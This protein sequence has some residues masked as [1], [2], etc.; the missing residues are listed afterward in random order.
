MGTSGRRRANRVY[1]NLEKTRCQGTAARRRSVKEGSRSSPR[2]PQSYQLALACGGS[3]QKSPERGKPL[4]PAGS[5]LYQPPKK[6]SRGAA[7]LRRLFT[8]VSH[9]DAILYCILSFPSLSS[10]FYR[11]LSFFQ[12]FSPLPLFDCKN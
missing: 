12:K 5:R 11:T 1:Y 4:R 8:G 2:S 10:L 9:P 7:E 6:I 3:N